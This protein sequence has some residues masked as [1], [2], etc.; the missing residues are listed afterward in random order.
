MF[1]VKSIFLL[2]AVVVLLAIA[3]NTDITM[4]Y[5][6]F[7]ISF[8]MFILSFIHLQVNIPDISRSES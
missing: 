6:F 5:I 2:I 1:T 8:V 7:V 4:V 3:W